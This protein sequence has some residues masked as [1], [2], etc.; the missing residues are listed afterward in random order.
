MWN[1][2]CIAS[3]H[4][5]LSNRL[6]AWLVGWVFRSWSPISKTI[7]F[8]MFAFFTSTRKEISDVVAAI[9]CNF[10]VHAILLLF[11]FA[12]AYHITSIIS[13]PM[14]EFLKLQTNFSILWCSYVEL[15]ATQYCAAIARSSRVM[16]HIFNRWLVA[17]TRH[18]HESKSQLYLCTCVA[19]HWSF[20][21]IEMNSIILHILATEPI[22]DPIPNNCQ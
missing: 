3:F 2:N 6:S 17:N 8:M 16:C 19:L 7:S 15:T 18:K 20:I 21:L 9:A 13:T 1:V 10:H 5:Y 11:S 4:V 22:F 12:I 14:I